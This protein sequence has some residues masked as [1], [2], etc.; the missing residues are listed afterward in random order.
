MASQSTPL[1][2]RLTMTESVMNKLQ[3]LARAQ[4]ISVSDA[5]EQAVNISDLVIRKKSEPGT[6]VL[7]KRGS[8]YE[9]L[10]L[11]GK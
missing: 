9:Q 8:Q 4:N 10:T 11:G 7:F 2:D 5:L 6:K 3:E 1:P